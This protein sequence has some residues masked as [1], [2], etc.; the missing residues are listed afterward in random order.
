ML[1]NVSILGFILAGI[2]L[3]FSSYRKS[4]NAY[5]AAY[6][7]GSNLFS[8]IYYV[9]FESQSVD[10]AA[11]FA[12][13][14]TPFYLLNQ[15]FLHLYVL[16]QQKEF[17]FKPMY[18]LFFVPF[19]LILLNVS[20][21]V[22]IPFS[23]KVEFAKKFLNNAELLY[24]AKLLFL[25]YYYQSLFR[26]AF[27]LIFLVFTCLTYYK[28]RHS[29]DYPKSKF[30][31]RNFVFA[32]LL[33]SASLNCLSFLFIINKLFIQSFDMTLFPGVSFATVN[34]IVSYLYAGQNLMLL[35][36]PQILFQE[37]F[38]LASS[39]PQKK[40]L[41]PK[42]DSSISQERFLEI[43]EIIR[44]Y[45]QEKPYLSQ[46][47]TLTNISQQT[48]VPAHQLSSYFNEFVKSPFN[49]WK[50]KLRIEF[51]V[52]EINEGKLEFLTIEGLATSSGFASRSNFNKA[53]FTIMNQTPSEYIKGLKK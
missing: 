38:H 22:F 29:F 35:F 45:M 42:T 1:L 50:N 41:T 36:F 5:L 47:F 37:Q 15:P 17:T 4:K 3:L 2:M 52:S 44:A 40:D 26:P 31:E 6:L 18:F 20:P 33:I 46:G 27:N 13:N 11:L 8:L 21:Y 12:I 14:F 53:F 32:I 24:Q 16:S 23:Q 34:S 43:D 28:L 49:D 19:A 9:I 51:V 25:P 7:L 30:N 10:L 39:E 48:G